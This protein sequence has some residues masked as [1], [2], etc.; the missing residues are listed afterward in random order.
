MILRCAAKTKGNIVFYDGGAGAS[1]SLN[2]T[3]T[4]IMSYMEDD[5]ARPSAGF[6]DFMNHKLADLAESWAQ[7]GFYYGHCEANRA[8]REDGEIPATMTYDYGNTELFP[9]VQRN[10]FLKSR[11]RRS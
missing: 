6:R 5:G 2:K 1:A 11:I 9:G 8:Q 7:E 3:I 4:D 10:L